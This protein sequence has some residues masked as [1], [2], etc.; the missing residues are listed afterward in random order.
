MPEI[1]LLAVGA[2]AAVFALVNGVNDGSTLVASGLKVPVIRPL[3]AAALLAAAA[4][5]VPLAVGTAVAQT[6][7]GRLVAF[8]SDGAPIAVLG[9]VGATVVV[10]MLARRGLPTSLTLAVIGGLTG[11]GLAAGLAVSWTTVAVVLALAGLAPM[12]GGVLAFLVLRSAGRAVGLGSR[13]AV[14]RR[15][16]VAGFALQCV[17]YG[18]NDGQKMLA[19]FAVALGVGL[20]REPGELWVYASVF[21]LFLA[22]ALAGLRRFSVTVSSGVLASRPIHSVSATIS[23]SLA[24]LTASLAGSPVSMTQALTGGLIGSGMSESAYRIRWHLAR[25]IAV[26]WIVTLPAALFGGYG[27]GLLGM[28]VMT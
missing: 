24:V 2:V 3:V 20:G 21:V 26:A 15:L 27:L 28:V 17:A 12:V 6:F 9:V 16:H 1:E 13:A 23:A 7:A 4:A 11:A 18:A 22:G 8:D 14:V 5:L 19:V 25:S 10:I